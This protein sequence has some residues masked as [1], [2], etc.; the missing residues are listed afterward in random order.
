MKPQSGNSGNPLEYSGAT[1]EVSQ[2]TR[3]QRPAQGNKDRSQASG[4]TKKA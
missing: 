4:G 1:P 3:D 2:V